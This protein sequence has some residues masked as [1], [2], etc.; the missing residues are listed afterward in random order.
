MRSAI[1]PRARYM[2]RWILAGALLL[3]IAGMVAADIYRWT[4]SQGRVHYSNEPPPKNVDAKK[5][6]VDKASDKSQADLDEER[7]FW[8][9]KEAE[10]RKRD[11]ARKQTRAA[12]EAEAQVS[13][14]ERAI[15]CRV[16][17]EELR[18]LTSGQDKTKPMRERESDM[19][20]AEEDIYKW[21]G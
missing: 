5:I 10:F 12:E 3:G 4:D 1:S 21:C 19:Q 17:Q 15:K 13:E 14:S 16:A 8:R 20:R 7:K 2:R 6:E 9:E 11:T 18:R